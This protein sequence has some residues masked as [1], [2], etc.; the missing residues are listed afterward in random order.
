MRFGRQQYC[1]GS[2]W[3]NIDTGEEDET[4]DETEDESRGCSGTTILSGTFPLNGCDDSR[5]GRVNCTIPSATHDQLVNG[6]C[7]TEWPWKGNHR[8]FHIA[9]LEGNA[10]GTTAIMALGEQ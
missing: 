8:F 6:S 7:D 1:N 9:M 10:H 5:R 4:E 2:S 3:I